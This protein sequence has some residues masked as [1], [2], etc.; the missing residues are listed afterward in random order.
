MRLPNKV[1]SFEESVIS[2]FPF[3]L[4]A[5]SKEDISVS[6][7][8]EAIGKIADDIGE[9]IEILDCLYALGKIEFNAETGTLNYVVRN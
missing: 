3:V 1:N 2:K 7:L 6:A 4:S 5:L 8:Y 9:F